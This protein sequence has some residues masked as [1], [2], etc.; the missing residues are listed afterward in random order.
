[1]SLF[2]IAVAFGWTSGVW[3]FDVDEFKD[4]MAKTDVR[5]LA[6]LSIS[7]LHWDEQR[8]IYGGGLNDIR[9][10][11]FVFEF[12][13]EKLVGISKTINVPK[14]LFNAIALIDEN[15]VKLGAPTKVSAGTRLLSAIAGSNFGGGQARDLAMEWDRG[16]ETVE[17][18]ITAIDKPMNPTQKDDVAGNFGAKYTVPHSCSKK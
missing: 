7:R 6:S 2:L 17:I 14:T 16:K 1:L 10:E 5:A 4:G 9:L 3:A 15:L 13:I 8:G 11:M 18:S 12:C